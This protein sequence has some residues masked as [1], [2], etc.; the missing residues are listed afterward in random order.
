MYGG[1]V[2]LTCERGVEK[3][4]WCEIGDGSAYLLWLELEAW[5]QSIF[6]SV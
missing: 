2:L 5:S 1:K 6:E 3:A 4:V